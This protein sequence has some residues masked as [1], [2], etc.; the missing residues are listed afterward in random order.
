MSES[1]QEQLGL[2]AKQIL[3]QRLPQNKGEVAITLVSG[4]ASF[5]RYFRVRSE[6]A[7]FIAVD[8]P[9]EQENSRIFVRICNLLREAGV[10]VPKVFS[11]DYD[12]GFMLLDDFG[13]E[14]YL[15]RLV[16]LQKAGNQSEI[17]MLYKVAI[18]SLIDIQAGVYKEKL[19]PYD[20]SELHR[21]MSLFE[22][23]FCSQFLQL[24]LK[25]NEKALIAETLEFL[26][27]AALSQP[28]V[29]VHRDYHSRNLMILG[30]KEFGENSTPGIIDFQDAVSGPYTYDLV[31]LLRDAYI[32]WD[33]EQV[34][35]WALYYLRQAKSSGLVKNI[36][37][38]QFLRD[39]DLMGLQRQLK[40]IGIFA[41]LC[42][43]DNKPRY[44]AD[45]PLV[46]QY[47]LEV[48]QRYKELKSF[49][50]WFKHVVEPT[51][52]TKL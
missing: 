50:D 36:E 30:T 14:I 41:R 9:P 32:R 7:R 34:D 19:D 1:R 8:S 38:I 31:S 16:Y 37:E 25:E 44:L 47:F 10:T 17:N 45:I 20:K 27:E 2:W 33:Q 48:G 28:K 21:E 13:D 52:R 24:K 43:R 4:D 23:W 35:G 12:Q 18:D 51:A 42:I 6:E 46:I 26:E 3:K 15:N 22:N 29:A 11:V 39:F 5:R 40:V 49:V